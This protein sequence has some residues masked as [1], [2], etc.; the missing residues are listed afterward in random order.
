MF[1]ALTQMEE[2]FLES[3]VNLFVAFA[4]VIR[5]KNCKN[6]VL[7]NA[8]ASKS[9]FES[10]L[11][12][13]TIYE[14]FGDSWTL[15]SAMLKV[16]FPWLSV[17]STEMMIVGDSKYNEPE[18]VEVSHSVFPATASWKQLTHYAQLINSG[19]FEGYDEGT[20]GNMQR[21]GQMK[22]PEFDLTQIDKVPVA[23]FVGK[24]DDLAVPEDTQWARDQIPSTIY[25]EE[26]DNFD[27]GSFM[28]GKDMSFMD[29]VLA[30]V[31]QQLKIDQ[32][33]KN[34]V[35]YVHEI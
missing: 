33:K 24:Q 35:P 8:A 23:M 28:L 34:I 32:I 16:A 2:E 11:K 6:P 25:Y 9:S 20:L 18:R 15:W 17:M 26:I 19:L 7:K 5:L 21:Y 30:I 13:N 10:T 31:A 12:K 4:P 3:R 14:L 22:Q 29:N 27:H 1:Y